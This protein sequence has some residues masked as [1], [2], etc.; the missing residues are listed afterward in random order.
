MPAILASELA[1]APPPE[2]SPL[3]GQDKFTPPTII[4]ALYPISKTLVA[5][6]GLRIPSFVVSQYPGLWH[7]GPSTASAGGHSPNGSLKFT[8][9]PAAKPYRF[10]PP[11]R[12]RGSSC[13]RLLIGRLVV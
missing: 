8:G 10:R 5:V 12:P 4:A 3:P 2:T 7:Q 11:A 9:S 6:S 1:T 13:V